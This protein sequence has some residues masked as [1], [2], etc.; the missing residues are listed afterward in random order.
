[1]LLFF[2]SELIKK[3]KS[4]LFS[5]KTS[6]FANNSNNKPFDKMNESTIPNDGQYTHLMPVAIARHSCGFNSYTAQVIIL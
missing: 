3:H 4:N 5:I 1:M 6:L 2:K